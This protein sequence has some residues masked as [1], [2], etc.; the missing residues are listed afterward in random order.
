M[1]GN[2]REVAGLGLF[3]RPDPAEVIV[4]RMADV[5][6][7][8]IEIEA[9]LAGRHAAS[10]AGRHSRGRSASDVHRSASEAT[11][12]DTP[13]GASRCHQQRDDDPARPLAR[14]GQKAAD[15]HRRCPAG[16]RPELLKARCDCRGSDESDRKIRL[17]AADD[18]GGK[19]DGKH[20]RR[21]GRTAATRAE[22]RA[23]ARRARRGST[24]STRAERRSARPASRAAATR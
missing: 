6:P 21:D 22:R 3:P 12:R 10:T 2:R 8:Q 5:R 13:A 9:T 1:T 7:R 17:T 24:A 18:R 14:A 23:C 4:K 11:D 20:Q 19:G 15:E 16:R